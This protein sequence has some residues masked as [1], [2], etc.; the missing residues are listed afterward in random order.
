MYITLPTGR[1][2]YSYVKRIDDDLFYDENDQTFKAFADL[3]DGKIEFVEDTDL[4]GEYSWERELPDGTYIVYTREDPTDEPVAQ[5]QEITVK[6]GN[7]VTEAK[8]IGPG[9][10]IIELEITP[11]EFMEMEIIDC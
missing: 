1:N 6:F 2:F 5:A 4:T 11:D 8:I 9:D 7:Q 10:D 3:V